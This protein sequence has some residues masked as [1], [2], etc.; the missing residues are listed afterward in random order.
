MSDVRRY[1]AGR[2]E[3]RFILPA[4]FRNTSIESFDIDP[5]HPEHQTLRDNVRAF[6]DREPPGPLRF[7]R[8]Q[9]LGDNGSGLFLV[10][11]PGVG[12]THLLAAGYS[13]SQP[14]KLF[15]T[16]DEL[17]A[18]AGPLGIRQLSDVVKRPQLVCIDEIVLE[19]PGSIMM[20]VTLLQL[21][22]DS[23]T[24]VL[25]TANM[26]PQEAGGPD[27]W[28]Q[29]FDRELGQI[30]RIFDIQRIEGRDRRADRDTETTFPDLRAGSILTATPSEIEQ[31]LVDTHPMYDSAWM[32]HVRV[33]KIQGSIRPPIDKDRA[34]RFVRFIDRVYDRDVR[35]EIEHQ[36]ATPD[37][38]VEPLIG[39]RRYVWHVA[40]GRSRLAVLMNNQSV[41]VPGG[42]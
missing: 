11:P 23:G 28:M 21:M 42:A 19:D 29:V 5:N 35:L 18:A 3:P 27:G 13:A 20:L 22:I 37:E 6:V 26:P 24:R 8:R 2:H 31:Y 17:V 36:D 16:F 1:I 38:L 32:E 7:W 33:I 9:S 4:R 15:A 41:N 10:G 34:L 14:P 12:K 25:A 39:D 30:A 40:R